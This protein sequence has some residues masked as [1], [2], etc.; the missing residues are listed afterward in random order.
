MADCIVLLSSDSDRDEEVTILP[1]IERIS[2]KSPLI[3]RKAV[4]SDDD[5]LPSFAD[6]LHQ[7][8]ELLT[9]T[10]TT[11]VTALE[12]STTSH[13]STSKEQSTA[14]KRKKTKTLSQVEVN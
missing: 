7:R 13:Q 5:D 10:S 4:D 3:K 9:T 14:G 12:D 8:K 2:N 6:H 11:T 1:L